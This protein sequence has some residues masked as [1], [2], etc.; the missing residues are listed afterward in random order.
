MSLCSMQHSL[1]R[2]D[3]VE[4]RINWPR[5]DEEKL[6][7]MLNGD[8]DVKLAKGN[9]ISMRNFSMQRLAAI[10]DDLGLILLDLT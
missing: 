4:T 10:I 3:I 8:E 7:N 2:V 1:I 5:E 9:N 6:M